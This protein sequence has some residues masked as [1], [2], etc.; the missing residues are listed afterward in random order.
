MRKICCPVGIGNVLPN[1]NG[2]IRFGF[3]LLPF[4][5]CC[6]VQLSQ[7]QTRESKLDSFFTAIDKNGE[8]HGSVLVAENGKIL[9]QKSFGYAD[10]QNKI[11]NT[12]NTLFQ[13]ASV[14]KLFTAIAVLQLYERK[15]LDLSDKFSKYFPDFPYTE[16]TIQQM[17]AMTSGLPEIDP[18]HFP[19][20]KQKQ[21]TSFKLTD[22]IPSLN[23]A[24]VPQSFKEGEKYRYCNTNYGLL[25]L[26]VEKVSGVKFDQYLSKNVF[27]PAGMKNT[28][29][30][31]PGTDP[32][33]HLNVA[34]NYTSPYLF[35]VVPVRFDTSSVDHLKYRYSIRA[36]EGASDIYTSVI[37]LMNFDLA[38]Q[39]GLL[40]KKENQKL[41]F[42]P[43]K[44]NNG[45]IFSIRGV[46][47]EIGEIGNFYW[48]FGTRLSLDSSLGNIVWESGGVP[49]ARA[50]MISNL[51]KRQ[52]VVWLDNKEN[53]SSMNNIFGVID[54]LNG[55]QTTIKKSK[56]KVARS[57]AKFLQENNSDVA[58]ARLI[59]MVQDSVNYELDEDELNE[60]AY[61]FYNNSKKEYAF[62]TLRAAIY[63][64][65]TSDN[66]FNSYGELLAKSGKKE[67]A[68][69]MYKKSLL[70]N[71][72]NE[73]SKMN[74]EKLEQK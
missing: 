72:K 38:L 17:L 16:V 23:T 5:V 32:Y 20:W 69:I 27:G 58:F 30:R 50:N 37:D 74:L 18:I 25:A 44:F 3:L 68:I 41:I 1:K 62:E 57:F 28:F 6:I 7:A 56:K 39:K 43:S 70:L 71:P 31:L 45:K 12:P 52:F 49:G 26:L 10:I 24:K 4:F 22:I 51:T 66:L 59:S 8:V 34:Y 67:E 55:K 61:E 21:D 47:N 40:L 13:I 73:D 36:D 14:S 35:S 19:I 2:Q 15:K 46:S 63:L 33:T 48:G 54:I 64:F 53:T 42:S 9:Y 60:M 11:P 65:P 29:Q